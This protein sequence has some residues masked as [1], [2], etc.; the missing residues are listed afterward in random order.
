MTATAPT[1]PR[2]GASLDPADRP[3]GDHCEQGSDDRP[4]DERPGPVQRQEGGE[5]EQHR[6]RATQDGAPRQAGDDERGR[7]S[8]HRDGLAPAVPVVVA[9]RGTALEPQPSDDARTGA[10]G[11]DQLGSVAERHRR[12]RGGDEQHQDA[13]ESADDEAGRD[14]QHAHPGPETEE[15]CADAALP[16]PHRHDSERDGD[17]QRGQS[18]RPAVEAGDGHERSQSDRPADHGDERPDARPETE[19][20]RAAEVEGDGGQRH[21]RA[22]GCTEQQRP[23]DAA[24][25]GPVEIGEARPH[26]GA[27]VAVPPP[28]VPVDGVARARLQEGPE[29][30]DQEELRRPP[31]EPQWTGLAAHHDDRSLGGEPLD[32]GGG[33]RRAGDATG[34]G[35]R[36]EGFDLV[37]EGGGH[38]V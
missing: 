28:H 21:D 10:P 5:H 23:A 7:R 4:H 19:R 38:R 32:R 35:V 17:A 20:E 1:R 25:A 37:H 11:R 36:V 2:V 3:V 15:R 12:D 33:V 16:R 18:Q 22:D 26:A 14:A 8:R 9:G 29:H 34:D 30:H 13:G 27:V 31:A 6:R 24:H